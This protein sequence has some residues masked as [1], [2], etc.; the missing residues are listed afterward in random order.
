[1][2]KLL[3]PSDMT[4]GTTEPPKRA[5]LRRNASVPETLRAVARDVIAE[6]REAINNPDDAIAVHDFR[7]AMKRWRAFLRLLRPFLG[8]EGRRMQTEAAELARSLAGAR[9]A[10]TVLDALNDLNRGEQKLSPR[11]F[12][13]ITAR[14]E[15]LRAAA[16]GN[17]VTAEARTRIDAILAA[18]GESVKFWPFATLSYKEIATEL[19]EGYR[20]TREAIPRHWMAADPEALHDL[21]KR[22]VVHRYQMELIEPLWPRFGQFW[23]GET[24]RLRERLGH[25]Q[26]LIIFSQLTAPH[27][28][29]A[30]WRSRLT[31]LIA[32]RRADHVHAAGRIAKRLFIDA[33]KAFRRRLLALWDEPEPPPDPMERNA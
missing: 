17:T 12:A 33:P 30:Y 8:D 15:S 3:S 31:P 18:A 22:V 2:D 13:T 19:A 27:Q 26:D 10:R 32:A 28:A 20:R 16:E 23:V 29:L 7:K 1:L 24:Q 6:A 11:S 4:S 14:L 21:R 9:D 5:A 25:H